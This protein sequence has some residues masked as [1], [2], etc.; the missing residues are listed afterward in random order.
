ML[1]VNF[2][3]ADTIHSDRNKFVMVV[4]IKSK[5]ESK[6]SYSS[7]H[8]HTSKPIQNTTIDAEHLAFFKN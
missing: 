1:G 5:G 6:L 8:F 3:V 7:V 2:L 4:N